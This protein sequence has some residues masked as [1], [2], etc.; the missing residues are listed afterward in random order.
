M[1][2]N[3]KITMKNN[4]K[5]VTNQVKVAPK[6]APKKWGKP[7]FDFKAMIAKKMGKVAPKK[8]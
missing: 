2:T 5:K 8:K 1:T 4:M 6:V 3:T 7:S